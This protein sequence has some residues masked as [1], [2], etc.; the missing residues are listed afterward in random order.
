MTPFQPLSFPSTA[1]NQRKTLTALAEVGG[2][3]IDAVRKSAVILEEMLA[4]DGILRTTF[5]TPYQ[6]KCFKEN[7]RAAHPYAEI[8]LEP[9]H[10]SDTSLW[11]ELTFWAVQFLNII[12]KL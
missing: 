11:V 10:K 5:E 4:E 9:D 1:P 8:G 7:L 2:E 6:K 3:K 12:G